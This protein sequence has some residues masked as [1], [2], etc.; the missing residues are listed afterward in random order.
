MVTMWISGFSFIAAGFA[1]WGTYSFKSNIVMEVGEEVITQRDLKETISYIEQTSKI[2]D[3]KLLEEL[4]MGLLY[5]ERKYKDYMKKRGFE[6]QN[7]EVYEVVSGMKAFRDQNGN[8]SKEKY[9]ELLKDN[10]MTAKKF[11][12]RIRSSL[13]S[14][15]ISELFDNRKTSVVEI[16]NISKLYNRSLSLK[17]KVIEA[18][19]KERVSEQE[20]EERYNNKIENYK[21]EKHGKWNCHTD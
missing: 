12:E 15:Y 1:G 4:A 2:K 19:A 6:I 10:R 7:E 3:K 17:Y 8:F 18:Q 11:E 20:I 16:A 5:D 21:G 13:Y 9:F 14:V